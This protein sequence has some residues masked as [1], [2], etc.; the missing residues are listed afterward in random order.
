MH[1]IQVRAALHHF[2]RGDGG[3]ESSGEQARHAPGRV[4]R[5]SSRAGNFSR[6]H[7]QRRPGRN[8]NPAS[9]FGIVQFHASVASGRAQLI[10]QILADGNIDSDRA[11]RKRFVAAF[12]AHGKGRKFLAA[13][14]FPRRA[15]ERREIVLAAA[16]NHS[17]D[18][19]KRH[20][21]H[22]LDARDRFLRR[23]AF[24]KFHEQPVPGPQNALHRQALERAL[25]RHVQLAQK[26][27]A[28]SALEPQLVVVNDDDEFRLFHRFPAGPQMPPV[29]QPRAA[30]TEP[31]V[32]SKPCPVAT[33]PQEQCAQPVGGLFHVK[34]SAFPASKFVR[35]N[36]RAHSVLAIPANAIIS[37]S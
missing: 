23:S 36:G 27:A 13:N 15:P 24:A 4:G 3:I 37:L 11:L 35:K 33:Y 20:A 26:K 6:V 31:P 19:V 29:Y 34:R 10:H 21:E 16:R 17:R 2:V 18:G 25:Q 12:G 5:K 30:I 9:Q 7:Q 1:E 28:I 14:F 8:F 32:H 22:A